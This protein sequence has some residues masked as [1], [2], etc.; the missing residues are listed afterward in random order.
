MELIFV[1][2]KN[3]RVLQFP[4]QIGHEKPIGLLN[5][6]NDITTIEII[7]PTYSSIFFMCHSRPTIDQQI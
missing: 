3:I 1:F 6:K 5:N 4:A 7:R 2:L